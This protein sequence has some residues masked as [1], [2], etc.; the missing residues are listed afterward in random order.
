[1]KLVLELHQS[2][3]IEYSTIFYK[4]VPYKLFIIVKIMFSYEVVLAMLKSSLGVVGTLRIVSLWPS[5][6]PIPM[7]VGDAGTRGST[8]R[9]HV[10]L[11]M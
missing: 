6:D 8:C 11:L 4:F 2:T 9:S 5:V 7:D 10:L 1:M 3:Y